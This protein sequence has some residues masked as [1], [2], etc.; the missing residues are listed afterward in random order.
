MRERNRLL[1]ADEDRGHLH[2]CASYLH[3]RGY[4]VSTAQTLVDTLAVL[5]EARPAIDL[6]ILDLALARAQ[7]WHLVRYLR[8]A[9]S[10]SPV[11]LPIIVL[12]PVLGV[13]LEMQLMRLEVNDWLGKPV[14]PPAL[15]VPKIRALLGQGD[16]HG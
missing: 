14:S 16:F 10:R 2:D 7:D 13:D 9:L 12:A 6:L 8:G 1:L 5:I 15:L 11:A 3:A 4:V